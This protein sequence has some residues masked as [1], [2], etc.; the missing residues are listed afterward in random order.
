MVGMHGS[1]QEPHVRASAEM[2]HIHCNPFPVLRN[3]KP[4]RLPMHWGWIY[5]SAFSAICNYR[6]H[7][8]F[9][10]TQVDQPHKVQCSFYT[11]I[12]A[13]SMNGLYP[14]NVSSFGNSVHRLSGFRHHMD[15]L[16]SLLRH[17]CELIRS[18]FMRLDE[19]HINLQLI[20]R[21]Q[22]SHIFIIIDTQKEK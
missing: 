16:Q 13:K 19:P 15:F 4:A 21:G 3:I 1:A 12:P 2:G 9:S 10:R 8:S 20:F 18:V 22:L 6:S 11:R 17:P 14:S 5:G 7:F